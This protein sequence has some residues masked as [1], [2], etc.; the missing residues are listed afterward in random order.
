MAGT[1]TTY[2]NLSG[3]YLAAASDTLKLNVY[4]TSAA[5]DC[6]LKI[7]R[8]TCQLVNIVN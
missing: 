7:N 8:L 1:R 5:A 4:H 3:Y 2:W 6:T